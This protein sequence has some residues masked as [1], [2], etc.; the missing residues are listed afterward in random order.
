MT[1]ALDSLSVQMAGPVSSEEPSDLCPCSCW[2]SGWFFFLCQT[3]RLCRWRPP[4][5]KGLVF[6]L[7][8][9]SSEWGGTVYILTK[10]QVFLEWGQ[11]F[12]SHSNIFATSWWCLPW[13]CLH[14]ERQSR[15]SAASHRPSTP[16]C[17]GGHRPDWLA[18]SSLGSPPP[19]S[20]NRPSQTAQSEGC[21]RSQTKA[22][23]WKCWLCS[24]YN[25]ESLG[26]ET[27]NKHDI[28]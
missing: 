21:C 22:S 11:N 8:G 27:G 6:R 18:S 7:T 14:P 23:T 3:R 2:L 17:P 26:V 9:G 13:R 12:E 15:C 10:S 25:D 28:F 16:C 24:T 1:T 5:R 19:S 20:L 4:Q